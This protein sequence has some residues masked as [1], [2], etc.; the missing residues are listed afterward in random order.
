VTPKPVLVVEHEADADG[1]RLLPALR[2]AGLDPREVRTHAGEAVPEALDRFSG[3]VSLG[4]AMFVSDA[5]RYPFIATEQ[6]LFRAAID[7]DVPALG[8]C[9]GGQILASALGATLTRGVNSHIGWDLVRFDRPA[10]PVVGPL[11][12]EALLFEWHQESFE[13]PARTT[14]LGGSDA[15][16]VQAF[17]AGL[18]WG[19]QFHIE[20]ERRHIEAWSTMDGGPESLKA[21][22]LTAEELLARSTAPL[23]RQQELAD[24]VFAAFASVVRARG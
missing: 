19:F 20:V 2:G 22:G 21:L 5:D 7:R 11:A 15:V 1:G 24:R 23:E 16:P 12:P 17:R 18:A 6:E 13:L 9:L 4:G 14:L 10:D 8:I 3:F